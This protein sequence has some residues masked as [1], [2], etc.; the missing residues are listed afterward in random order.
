MVKFSDLLTAL[1][2]N[3]Y[4]EENV[5]CVDLLHNYQAVRGFARSVNWP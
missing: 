3:R 2:W 5:Q 1:K 4:N